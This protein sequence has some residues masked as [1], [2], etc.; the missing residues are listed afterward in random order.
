YRSLTTELEYNLSAQEEQAVIALIEAL[1]AIFC[2]LPI[3]EIDAMSK[4]MEQTAVDLESIR[5]EAELKEQERR[6][7]ILSER[8]DPDRLPQEGKLIFYDDELIVLDVE[9]EVIFVVMLSCDQHSARRITDLIRAKR[10][11]GL[12]VRTFETPASVYY[13]ATDIGGVRYPDP[14]FKIPQ[15]SLMARGIFPKAADLDREPQQ[16]QGGGRQANV[17]Q[18]EEQ[19]FQVQFCPMELKDTDAGYRPPSSVV[20]LDD[21]IGDDL[22]SWIIIADRSCYKCGGVETGSEV[23]IIAPAL[24]Q[25]LQVDSIVTDSAGLASPI[26]QSVSLAISLRRKGTITVNR[27]RTIGE[28]GFT[29]MSDAGDPV[30]VTGEHRVEHSGGFDRAAF[31]KWYARWKSKTVHRFDV[32]DTELVARIFDMCASNWEDFFKQDPLAHLRRELTIVGLE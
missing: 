14:D 25:P 18:W 22:N 32:S 21:G 13:S 17:A 3:E 20:I 7:E 31:D 1:H 6:R 9:N 11:D 26:L 5:S 15:D 2:Y 12:T 29:F 10:Y 19:S 23:Q 16:P 24:D 4:S 28:T 30:L 8:Y 27:L